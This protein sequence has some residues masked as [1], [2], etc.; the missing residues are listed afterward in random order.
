MLN[1]TISILDFDIFLRNFSK[2]DLANK[3]ENHAS[4]LEVKSI[5]EKQN[6]KK[7]IGEPIPNISKKLKK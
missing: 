5:G 2:K 7:S 4:I 6:S 1:D 3:I